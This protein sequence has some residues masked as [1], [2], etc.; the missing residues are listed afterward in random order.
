MTFMIAIMVQKQ[1]HFT[2]TKLWINI[3]MS[4]TAVTVAVDNGKP[5]CK[6]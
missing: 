1:S 3:L 6:H 5:Q 4:E 2:E